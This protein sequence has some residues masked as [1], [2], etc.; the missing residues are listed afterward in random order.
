MISENPNGGSGKGIICNALGKLKKVSVLDGK[1]FSFEK[2]FPYQ[3]ISIDTQ[4][5]VF[6]D[7]KKNFQ[8]ESLFSLVTEGITLERK[9]KDAIHLDVKHSPK[10]MITTNYTIQGN[11]GSFERRKFE[12]EMSSFFSA[13]N[14]PK[15]VLGHMLFDDWDNEEWLK[16]DNFMITCLQFFLKNGLIESEFKNL[17][18]RKF[19]NETRHEFYE[20]ANESDRFDLNVR[21]SKSDEFDK[22]VRENIDVQKWLTHAKFSKWLESFATFKKWKY[23]SVKSNGIKYFEFTC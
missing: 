3:T 23:L 15:D 16:F 5:L 10:I 14:T 19:I 4:I 22:F 21:Y 9:N 12:I 18:T 17:E 1:G 11:G 20:W 2:S 13:N 7:V 8:F 6:D